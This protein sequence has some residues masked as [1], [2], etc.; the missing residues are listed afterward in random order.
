MIYYPYEQFVNDVKAL[1][2]LTESYQPDTLI[3]IARGGLTLGHA[4]ASATGNRQLLTVN[5]ILYEG[6]QRGTSC[7]IFNVPELQH[8]N[9]VLLL[10]DIVDSGQ[11]IKEVLEHLQAS[12]PNV[13]FKIASIY[14]KKSATI[15]P[16]FALHE[17]DDWI[18]FF[19]EKDFLAD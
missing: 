15:Q 8:A 7:E 4:Y 6:D 11:T 9:K 10:D 18:E 16:D 19:W 12:F 1:V 2:K 14:Y 5:S 17:A 3:A 13:I